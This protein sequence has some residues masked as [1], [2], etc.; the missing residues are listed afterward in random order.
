MY[1][2]Q[3]GYYTL[4]PI[5][6]FCPPFSGLARLRYSTG[7]NIVFANLQEAY[8]PSNYVGLGIHSNFLNNVNF[9][10]LP[11]FLLPL[12][13]FPLRRI[14]QKSNDC[15]TRPR[16]LKYGKAFICEVPLT[17][18]LFNSFNICTSIVVSFQTFKWSNPSSLI[19]SLAASLL[20]VATTGLF[21]KFNNHFSEFNEEFDCVDRALNLTR[22][23]TIQIRKLYSFVLILEMILVPCLL[24]MQAMFKVS[25]YI[26][27]A[28]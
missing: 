18:F 21:F 7:F 14:G 17:I 25:L 12:L 4:I 8:I 28:L 24:G 5:N 1:I 11:L 22:S 15:Q 23:T 27:L 16:C 9:M 19:P 3:L 13:Y 26:V 2:I 20:L 10:L 6:S